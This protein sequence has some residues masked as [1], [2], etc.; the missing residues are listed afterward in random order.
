MF[1]HLKR[2]FPFVVVALVVSAV[3]TVGR[4]Q[5]QLPRID[6]T[7]ESLFIWPN[8]PVVAPS[9]PV[10]GPAPIAPAPVVAAPS[11]PLYQPSPP[12]VPSSPFG[13][14]M[15]PP[16][17]SDP[18]GMIPTSPLVGPASGIATTVPT[19]P[20][21][22]VVAPTGA[23]VPTS[24]LPPPPAVAAAPVLPTATL[25]PYGKEY[26]RVSPEGLV[27]PVGS[28]MLL[29][30][31]IIATDGHLV[32]NQRVDWSINPCGAGMFTELGFRDR[33]Q[34]L[35]FLEA[36]QRIDNWNATSTTAVVPITLNTSTPDPNDDVPIYRGEAW[37]TVT[38]PVEGTSV[39]TAEA[40]AYS[41]FNRG[42]ST[43]YWVDAQWFFPQP[44]VVEPGRSHTLTT[45]VVRKTDGA[46]LAGWIVRYDVA[47]GAL[48]Y[49]GGNFIESPTDANGRASVEVTP[50]DAG[51]GATTVGITVIRPPTAGPAVMP[52]LQLGRSVTTVSWA[53]G[54]TAVPAVPVVPAE[55]PAPAPIAS[56][57]PTLPQNVSPPAQTPNPYTPAPNPYTPAPNS[58]AAAAGKPRLDASLRLTGTDQVSVGQFAAFEL[59]IV[60]R[61]DGVARHIQ[62]TD[63]FDRGLRHP[64]AKPNEFTVVNANLKDLA[65]GESQV[66]P[67]TFQV[68]DGGTQC[69]EATVT[70]DGAD[71]V[72]QKGCVTARQAALEVKIIGPRQT[73]IGDTANFSATITNVGD[74]TA[75][76]VELVIH[77]DAAIVPTAAEPGA[78]PLADNGL[79]LK[80]DSLAPAEKRTF[81]MQGQCRTATNRACTRA[82]I[83]AEGGVNQAA[84][85]CVEILPPLSTG[86]LPA[87]GGAPTASNLTLTVGVT[88]TPAH[89]GDKLLINIIIANAGQQ[90]EKGVSMRAILPQEL[91]PDTTQIQPAAEN[92][93]P[94]EKG[95]EIRFP[96]VAE[97]APGEQLRYLITV[98]PSRT[99]RVQVQAQVAS[100]SLTTPK[101]VDSDMIDIV[102]ASP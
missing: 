88:K 22:P 76:N 65:P 42:T 14:V 70:A 7:G 101:T 86:A 39:V 71:P 84:E 61:G 15:A 98:T 90:L 52:R 62:I 91:T 59:T 67:L 45:T 99:G 77:C 74:V 36:P 89:V 82:T 38:S 32:M 96:T 24:P 9:A 29:K 11:A 73:V 6:P 75:A 64:A 28:E 87:A 16:V 3:S 48:G 55:S 27:A 58:N 97:V 78:Q 21:P 33:G 13:N 63:R 31:G 54:V 17:Y 34:L 72:S 41:E 81:K 19:L 53:P 49:E 66:V 5:L 37:V 85:A 92:V 1:W 94:N 12:M 93:L 25:V 95:T 26:L 56:P 100:T 102:S 44:S 43:I 80:I 46:P 10:V 23:A 18:P 35:G 57:P 83:T 50:K 4:A 30:A 8:A 79:L 40:T 68:V 69:H 2:R 47:G 60:N 51:G 20:P